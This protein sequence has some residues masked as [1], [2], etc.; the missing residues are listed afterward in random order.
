MF[1]LVWL[2]SLNQLVFVTP[3]VALS[4]VFLLEIIAFCF[5]ANRS[6]CEG[7][8]GRLKVEAVK[9]ENSYRALLGVKIE[10]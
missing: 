4:Y 8:P 1:I 7:E 3:Y 10:L 9:V 6:E 2:D 5:L